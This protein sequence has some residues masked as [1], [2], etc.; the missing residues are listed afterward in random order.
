MKITRLDTNTFTSGNA[1]VDYTL[2]TR[3]NAITYVFI[4]R[5]DV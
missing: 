1:V 4:V 2:V 5:Y 3:C